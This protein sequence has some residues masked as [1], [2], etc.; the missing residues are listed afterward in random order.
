MLE[1]LR[2]KGTVEVMCTYPGCGVAWWIDPLDPRLNEAEHKWDC[3]ENHRAGEKIRRS[4]SLLRIRHGVRWGSM[5]GTGPTPPPDPNDPSGACTMM[6]VAE[7]HA[8]MRDRED[9]KEGLLTWKDP[10]D[11]VPPEKALASI[12]WDRSKWPKDFA[13][14]DERLLAEAGEAPMPPGYVQT[15]GYRIAATDQIR[16]Y[17]FVPCSRPG[18][19]QR[20]MVDYDNPNFDASDGYEVGAWGGDQLPEP[21]W[22]G[23][24]FKCEEGIGTFGPQ[25]CAVIH[26]GAVSQ[27]EQSMKVKWTVWWSNRQEGSVLFY[28]PPPGQFKARYGLLVYKDE[29]IFATAS[30]LAQNIR[31]GTLDELEKALALLRD[32]RTCDDVLEELRLHVRLPS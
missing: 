19:H 30:R 7:G 22:W 17:T 18:C 29:G 6:N 16:I 14:N 28:E 5:T 4:M 2:P 8:L 12:E 24:D 15:V 11:L 13:L 25:P 9:S 31:W 1:D 3:G 27:F 10:S 23:R 32:D 20:V 21:S 26:G